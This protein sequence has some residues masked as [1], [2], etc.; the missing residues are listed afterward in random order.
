M[1]L[2]HVCM[3]TAWMKRVKFLGPF[4]WLIA[5]LGRNDIFLSKLI[6]RFFQQNPG[7]VWQ[8]CCFLRLSDLEGVIFL[9]F[10]NKWVWVKHEVPMDPQNW[11]VFVVNHVFVR[12]NHF[13]S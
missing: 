2:N 1:Y 11:Q 12:V 3:A 8:S 13:E 6:Q 9:M 10:K 7:L 4:V 5:S